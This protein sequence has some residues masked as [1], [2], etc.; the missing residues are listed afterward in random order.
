MTLVACKRSHSK[1]HSAEISVATA[2]RG[3]LKD[4][5]FGTTGVD[6]RWYTYK[7]FNA[8]DE[9]KQVLLS[10]KREQKQ[11]APARLAPIEVASKVKSNKL[12]YMGP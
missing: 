9:A 2:N 7:E 11:I 12:K 1:R 3:S 10:R 4:G 6:I 8:L 5:K